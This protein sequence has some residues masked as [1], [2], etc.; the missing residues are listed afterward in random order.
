MDNQNTLG[1]HGKFVVADVLILVLMDNQNT[2]IFLTYVLT[3][4]VLIL[5]LMDN[6]NTDWDA[7]ETKEGL[8]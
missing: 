4:N 7:F 1:D 3:W 6:Q 5:V 2:D 8:S